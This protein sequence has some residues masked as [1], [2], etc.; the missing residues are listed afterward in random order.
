MDRLGEYRKNKELIKEYSDYSDV[1]QINRQ[2]SM[3][4]F[5]MIK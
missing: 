2:K 5:L 1:V 4:T 3:K